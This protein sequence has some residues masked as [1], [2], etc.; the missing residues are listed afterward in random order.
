ML[1][2][3][4]GESYIQAYCTRSGIEPWFGGNGEHIMAIPSTRLYN[5]RRKLVLRERP[6]LIVQGGGWSFGFG[7]VSKL[8]ALPTFARRKTLPSHFVE[9]KIERPTHICI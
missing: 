1:F 9:L 8:I 4:C 5:T 6:L 7:G 2:S 3:N